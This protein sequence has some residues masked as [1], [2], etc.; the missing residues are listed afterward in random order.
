MAVL[1]DFYVQHYHDYCS[2]EEIVPNRQ[3]FPVDGIFFRC[4]RKHYI[5]FRKV[6][7]ESIQIMTNCFYPISK[8]TQNT[9]M[10][11]PNLYSC[12]TLLSKKDGCLIS[13]HFKNLLTIIRSF[14]STN[15]EQ[16]DTSSCLLYI[17]K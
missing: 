13:Q 6:N 3:R 4:I 7:F 12:L 10:R 17:E 11:L 14:F 5:F 1:F 2:G 16:S 8:T 9:I 15:L